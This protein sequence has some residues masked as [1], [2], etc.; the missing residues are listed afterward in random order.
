M[1]D[2]PQARFTSSPLLALVVALSTG[3]ALER[4][5][6]LQSKSILIFGA[7]MGVTLFSIVLGSKRR[8]T[9]VSLLL[10]AAF[11]C[12]GFVR[13]SIESRSVRPN[14]IARMCDDGLIASGEP[15]ELTGIAS[16]QP[17]P[18]PDSFYLTL[19][20]ERIRFKGSERDASGTVLL[21][22]HA[23]EQR[24][25]EEFAALEL[26]HGARVRVMTTLGR[27][28]NFRNPGVLPLTEYLERKGYDAA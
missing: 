5:L 9:L 26:R 1:A 21:L 28:E 20:A 27:D 6:T 10:L 13:S 4:Y 11:F 23:H 3:I 15:V 17:E 14:R 7:V 18:A 24:V 25:R 22:A 8:R 12:A 16:G 2:L 19:Q